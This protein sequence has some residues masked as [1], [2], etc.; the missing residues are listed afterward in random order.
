MQASREE[1]W[2]TKK[3]EKLELK[4]VQGETGTKIWGEGQITITGSG[5][6]DMPG[7]KKKGASRRAKKQT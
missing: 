6:L 1:M 2:N 4:L 7:K 3:R 5:G